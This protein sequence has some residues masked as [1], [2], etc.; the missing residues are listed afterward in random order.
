M[1]YIVELVNLR[2]RALRDCVNFTN[3][4]FWI[5]NHFNVGINFTVLLSYRAICMFLV[6]KFSY[7]S[8]RMDTLPSIVYTLSVSK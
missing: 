6:Q 1:V 5:K 7:P 4:A 3:Y 2:R 8:Q